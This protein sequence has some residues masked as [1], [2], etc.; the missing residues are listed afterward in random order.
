[1]GNFN[2]V[3]QHILSIAGTEM[4]P[5]QK[6]HQFGMNSVDT[7]IENSLFPGVSYA[8]IHFFF[9]FFHHFL[10]TGRMNASV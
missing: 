8:L 2:G 7:G 5:S 1:M 4:Q 9:G 6:L 3:L 10:N